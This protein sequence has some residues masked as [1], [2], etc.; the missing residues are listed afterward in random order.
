MV[1][2]HSSIT[3]QITEPESQMETPGVSCWD[4][5]YPTGKCDPAPT[6][7]CY[8]SKS[9]KSKQGERFLTP[10]VGPANDISHGERPRQ[11][12]KKRSKHAGETLEPRTYLLSSPTPVSITYPQTKTTISTLLSQPNT[13]LIYLVP[14]ANIVCPKVCELMR[15]PRAT[16]SKFQVLPVPPEIKMKAGG[17]DSCPISDVM[18]VQEVVQKVLKN[19]KARN[20]DGYIAFEDEREAWTFLEHVG[21]GVKCSATSG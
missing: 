1:S 8:F 11:K 16:G 17:S 13:K 19:T 21:K 15:L 6:K 20:F 14:Q 2:K 9:H 18:A 10:T 4:F 3:V 5:A 7:S 12:S